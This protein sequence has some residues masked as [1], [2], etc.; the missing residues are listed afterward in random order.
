[1]PGQ[2]RQA[3][4]LLS[5]VRIVD[6]SMGWSGP[7]AT[8]HFAD[9]GAEVI[10]VEAVQYFDWWRGWDL[11]QEM[12]DE[13]MY[14]QSAS[15]NLMNRNKS[16][17]TLDLTSQEGVD[18]LKRLV[19][20][21][22][23]V[24]ENQ[25][26]AVLPK[27]GLDYPR[28][29]EVNPRIIMISLP[30]FGCTG[31]WREYRAYG[32]TVE[33]ASGLPHLTGEPDWPPTMH[34]VAYGDA[35]AGINAAAA[36][37]VALYHRDRTG[38]G[39][40]IDLSQVEC[41]FP[42]AAHGIIDQSM[43]HTPPTRHG[44]RHARHAPHGVFPCAGEDRWVVITVTSDQEWQALCQVMERQ[45]LA[46]DDQF[47]S[48]HQRK[49]REKELEAAIRDWTSTREPDEIMQALQAR[50]VAAASVR[51][52][53]ELLEEPQLLER[54]FFKWLDRDYVGTQ[55]HTRPPFRISSGMRDIETPS[56]C[57]GEHN[58]EVLSRLLGLT[59]EEVQ[60]LEAKGIIGTIPKPSR[61]SEP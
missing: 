35:V 48:E 57:L 34:H 9:M 50:G 11:T 36:V 47:A 51:A 33:Q 56:P 54:D 14:E 30:A 23:V 13:R 37:L 43:N 55:L 59:P 41:L 1:M 44:N 3:A 21:S 6:L 39:Q 27:L 2:D 28:L 16:G 60:K 5:Q 25:A 15:F 24:I 53:Y 7:L 4:Y 29:R 45:D 10:K 8:R 17:I 26:G 52:P 20:I 38:Q 42:L 46:G 18:L 32:S 22:D 12:I 31:A 49:A 19:K 40:F 58:E 61:S